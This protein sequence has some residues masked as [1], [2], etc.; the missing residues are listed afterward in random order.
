MSPRTLRIRLLAGTA[1]ALAAIGT[2]ATAAHAA[3]EPDPHATANISCDT[4]NNQDNLLANLH[5]NL[6]NGAAAQQ[7]S[8]FVVTVKN[9]APHAFDVAP[10]ASKVDTWGLD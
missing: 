7:P 5:V 4:Y 2:G 6:S 10:G 9:Y 1:I 3:I 8:H